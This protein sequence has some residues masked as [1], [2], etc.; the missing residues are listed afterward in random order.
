MG[1]PPDV[2]N[3]LFLLPQW[4]QRA[5]A[6]RGEALVGR[7]SFCRFRDPSPDALT[8]DEAILC[9]FR[10]DRKAAGQGEALFA[11]GG[12]RWMRRAFW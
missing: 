9:R 1:R 5:G 3:G 8:P 12:G 2:T 4:D 6:G 11:D 10:N 7:V